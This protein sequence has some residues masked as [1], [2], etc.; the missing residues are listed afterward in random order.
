MAWYNETT[1][2]SWS[3]QEPDITSNEAEY[4]AVLNA[5]QNVETTD[6]IEI[7]ADSKLVV[8]QLNREWHIKDAK[9][10][11]LFDKIQQ[12][13]REKQLKVEFTWI[14]RE[15]NPAGKYLG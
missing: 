2:E 1:G 15:E 9:M 4:T 6:E 3:G 13:I 11:T 5:L 12:L 10:R 8:N 7:L 14:S